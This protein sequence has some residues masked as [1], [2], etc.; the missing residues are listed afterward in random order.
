MKQFFTVILFA[1]YSIGFSQDFKS[2]WKEVIQF[3]LDGKVKSAH[4]A[5]DKIYQ[6]A[7]KQHLDDQI[8]KCFFYQS[9][10]IQVTQEDSQ[11]IVVANLRQEIKDANGVEKALLQYVYATLL[12][13]Y[14]QNNNYTIS[15]RTNLKKTD[16]KDFNT[17]TSNDFTKEIN[18]A[19]RNSLKD[20]KLLRQTN[21]KEYASIFE[22]SPYTDSKKLSVY[23]FLFS[24][25]L[26]RR[27]T[28]LHISYPDRYGKISQELYKRP[29]EFI[30]FKTDTLT[31]QNLKEIVE[32]Y[33][34]NE[35]Y[36]LKNND[37]DVLLLQYKRMK[38]F[39]T[40]FTDKEYYFSKLDE[41]ALKTK[42]AY[43]LQD[44]RVDKANY[45]YS[46]T[47]ADSE[48][49]YHAEALALISTV[50]KEAENPNAKAEA[51]NL[52]QKILGKKLSLN[53][54]KK[55]YQ[56]QNYRAF[57]DYRNIDTITVK[58]YKIPID[59]LKKIG[60][61]DFYR[62]NQKEA[63]DRDSLAFDYIAKHT[64]IKT[65]LKILSPNNDHFDHTTEVL[66]DNLDLGNYLLFFEM[67]N[68]VGHEDTN[69]FAYHLIQVSNFD[70]LREREGDLDVFQVLDKKTGKPIENAIVKNGID[71]R[72]T[73]K[74]GKMGFSVTAYD[75]TDLMS[76]LFF[77]KDNDTLFT[78]YSRAYKPAKYDRKPD[79]KCMV[80]FDRAIYRPGQRVYFKGFMMQNKDKVKSVVPFVTVHV[81]I[82]D[83][84]RKELKEF[85]IQTNEFG[86]FTGEYDI[87][88]NLLTGQFYIKVEEPDDY[89]SDTKYYDKKTERHSFW[90]DINYDGYRQFPFRVEEYKRPTFEIKFDEIKENYTI[91]DSVK[92]RGNAR[93]LAGSNLNKAKVAYV[94]AKSSRT[95]KSYYDD[96]GEPINGETVTDENGNFK[97]EFVATDENIKDNEIILLN[98]NTTVTIT[99]VN[100]ETRKAVSNLKVGKETLK[101]VC[102][103]PGV[104]YKENK[105]KLKIDATTLNNFPINAKGTVTFFELNQKEYF[106]GKERYPES[107][108]IPRDVFEKLFPYEPYDK[109]DT[110]V[111]E[112]KLFTLPFDTEKTDTISLA[113]LKK[114]AL[115]K[116]KAVL[117]AKDTKG[118]TITAEN[119]FQLANKGQKANY[120]NFFSVNQLEDEKGFFVFEFHSLIPDLYIT[121]RMYDGVNK[122]AENVIQLKNGYAVVRF[123]KGS[124]Y[125]ND[126][127]FL[128]ATIWEGIYN[129]NFVSL[130]KEEMET[131]LEFEV[132]SMRNKIEPGSNENWS[133]IVK[134]SKAQAEI[135]A[136]MYDKSLDYFT[137]KDWTLE[138]FY[139]YT[140]SPSLDHPYNAWYNGNIHFENLYYPSQYFK[141]IV[142]EPRIEWFGFDF[143]Y[144]SKYLNNLYL[145]KYGAWAS[146]PSDAKKVSG[147]VS[148][149]GGALPGA[150]IVVKGTSRSTQTDFDGYFEIDVKAG[151]VLVV[152]FTGYQDATFL[153]GKNR[154]LDVKL[155]E[156]STQLEEVVIEGYH[157]ESKA[158]KSSVAQTTVTVG[159]DLAAVY[160]M[161][162]NN[163]YA[164]AGIPDF[165]TSSGSP[166]SSKLNNLI[167]GV[168][169]MNGNV[170]PLFVIDGIAVDQQTFRSLNPNDIE[171]AKILK[172]SEATAIYGSRGANGVIVITTKQGMKELETVKTRTNFNETAF[173]YPNLTTDE[174]GQIS[175]N[176][177][178]PESLTK[179]KLRLFAHNKKAETGY[180]ETEIVS[181]KDLMVMPNMPRFVREKDTINFAVKIVNLTGQVK[182]GNAI[183][184]LYD[185]ATNN[186]LDTIILDKMNTQPFSCNPRQSVVVNWTV[187][188]PEGVQ[189][190]RYKVIAKSGNLSDGEENI[191]PVLTDKILITESIPIWVKGKTKREFTFANLANTTSATLKNHALTFEYTSNPVW[192]ALQSLP[193]LMNYPYECA[194]QTF[195]KYYANCIAEKILTSNPKVESLMKKWQTS[196]IPKSKL[197][198][199]EEL[200]SV[201]LAETPWL[202]DA[203][204]DDQKNKRL[205]I[206]MDIATLNENNEK[207]LEKVAKMVLPS[208]G[209][210]WFSGGY[211]NP[212]ISQH[213]VSG[214]GHLNKL[215]PSDT[216]KY[217]AIISKAIPNMDSNFVSRYSKKDKIGR[218]STVNLNYLYTRSFFIKNYP[219]SKK[220]DS[221]IRL[222]IK[223]S[224]EDWLTYSLYEKG[225]L[226]LIMNRF[227]EK[228]F[229]KKIINSFRETASNNEEIGMYWIENND[230]YWWYKS[231]ISTQALLIEAFAEID[232]KTE[233]IDAMKVWL[234]KNKQSESW[235]TT[236]TTSEAVYAL[237]YQGSDWTSIKENTKI[238]IGD[239]KLL[240]KKL[241][242]KDDEL[243][244]GYFK[245]RFDSNE[246]NPKMGTISVD[247]KTDVPGFGG[248]YWQYFETLENVKTDSTQSM[249]IDKK[250]YKKVN[251]ELV[252]LKEDTVKVGDLLTV[253]LVITAKTNL[254][255]V[256]LK[257]M[258]ASCLEPVDVMSGYNWKDSLGFYKSTKD[259]ATN[260]FFDA[261]NKGTYV[262]EYDLRVTNVGTFNNGIST[263]QSMYAPEYSAHSLNTKIRVTK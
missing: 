105:N 218:L 9:K 33:Q 79:A 123:P 84:N 83:A 27:F 216:L 63:I 121:S 171:S 167:R 261:M 47:T 252:E 263:L 233:E 177:T 240:T 176:F 142:A 166:G 128:F 30:Q 179:W 203:E 172:N 235:S 13:R 75:Q 41:M 97:I 182:S 155:T 187:T 228:D 247:N 57:V 6:K 120:S 22:I 111:V 86:S 92:I 184:L 58:Y 124:N 65:A 188:I 56:N 67:K 24:E 222:Q 192:I 196:E 254:E 149:K 191:L 108:T 77:I 151:E 234:I 249:S 255:F 131:K 143:V 103:V 165:N 139:N 201:V 194:E 146:I 243:D 173:F 125:V 23:D 152:S 100:G 85:D 44:I 231:N 74:I 246:I 195:A 230:S 45:Y 205:A 180:F 14:Y 130:R 202:M 11:K 46:I 258:R 40:F 87:P 3:E 259:V 95:K 113:F 26:N 18:S 229:A 153:V 209:F 10:F 132:R 204:Q 70:Y 98:F 21:I 262:L 53:V 7:K 80:F 109:S 118:N 25:L 36:Y 221:I 181:Q 39:S 99:D 1:V 66:M 199:N 88:K 161:E 185:A 141:T 107:S 126:V 226:S 211:E 158:L 150:T 89:E 102:N 134:N 160:D 31:D 245:V 207:A 214:I 237:L 28:N 32:L 78:T 8:I 114:M 71:S 183:L 137:T 5:V 174:K 175:F 163:V 239:E 198:I 189:G 224:K 244:A 115:G 122:K 50:L 117:E 200:K 68:L 241:V 81:T 61:N 136:S 159:E 55:L 251:N 43:L 29:E 34:E 208:G 127:Q 119:T 93:N 193:Y 101:L 223:Q 186:P 51:E 242:K 20:E 129:N 12:E 69:A 147:V 52:Q 260:F 90:G 197:E 156:S 225:L 76:D 135:L 144:K 4:E 59:I 138:R 60:R 213:I 112:K 178:T 212:Y 19:Y 54:A 157:R 253:R 42:N 62:Y 49:N 94:I 236:K 72:V 2:E 154:I 110:K 73:N 15:K 238:R 168:T 248:V 145:K 164:M 37:T 190:L 17:W 256:H 16:S 250:I 170:E 257:D 227:N 104:L 217:D 116:Y 35:K 133:F 206:L 148:D 64:P 219:L 162:D 232:S 220:C 169:S 48:K 38:K 210:P 96:L 91:G 82:N 140:P 106:L 215:F